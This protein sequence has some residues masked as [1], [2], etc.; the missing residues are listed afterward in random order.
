MDAVAA[1]AFADWPVGAPLAPAQ[2]AAVLRVAERVQ[3][4]QPTGESLECAQG[5]RH[6]ARFLIEKGFDEDEGFR[7]VLRYYEWLASP[8]ARID[9][10]SVE[11][12]LRTGKAL[13]MGFDNDGR[14]VLLVRGRL[15][16]PKQFSHEHTLQSMVAVVRALVASMPGPQDTIAVVVDLAGFEKV[17]QGLQ[18]EAAAHMAKYFPERLT[19]IYILNA[20]LLFRGIWAVVKPLVA[21]RYLKMIHFL[22]TPAALAKV[23]PPVHL[24]IA[25]G[26]TTLPNFESW[27]EATITQVREGVVVSPHD[28]CKFVQKLRSDESEIEAARKQ[29][30]TPSAFL[31]DS[32]DDD[33]VDAP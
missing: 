13:S 21:A 9:M 16:A 7:K 30:G 1:Q 8:A 3:A 19:R 31:S 22:K 17:D 10:A 15:H 20:P 5:L 12:E 28:H 32:D 2:R 33:F 18:K 6:I 4:E 25:Y 27:T 23:I 14:A 24:P 26:G 29:A 11:T